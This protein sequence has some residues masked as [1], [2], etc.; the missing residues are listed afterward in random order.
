MFKSN[1]QDDKD[2]MRQIRILDQ[3][4]INYVSLLFH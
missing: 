3:Q 2:M 1:G 4:V